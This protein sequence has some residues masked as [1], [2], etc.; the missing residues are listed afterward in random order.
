M[1]VSLYPALA[2]RSSNMPAPSEINVEY[3]FITPELVDAATCKQLAL[4]QHDG[5]C[6]ERSHEVHVVLDHDDGRRGSEFPDHRG[7]HGPF[8]RGHSGSGLVEHDHGR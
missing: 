8:N 6:F 5:L 1:T 2:S 3:R 7:E 4:V